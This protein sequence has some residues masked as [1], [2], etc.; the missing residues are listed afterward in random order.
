MEKP[1]VT[2]FKRPQI[3]IAKLAFKNIITIYIL[4]KH[5]K[6]GSE[7]SKQAKPREPQLLE[8]L[9]EKDQAR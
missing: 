8:K 9:K 5:I 3:F 4:N 1:K 6:E 7:K 2:H